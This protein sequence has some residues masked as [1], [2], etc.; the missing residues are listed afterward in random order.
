[1]KFDITFSI[2]CHPARNRNS[3]KNLTNT[4]NNC[5]AV[6]LFH[7]TVHKSNDHFS[8]VKCCITRAG[9]RQMLPASLILNHVWIL[10]PV[11]YGYFRLRDD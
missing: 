6:K 7:N 11:I 4:M 3:G 2:I 5:K 9:V 10:L 8:I 1:M